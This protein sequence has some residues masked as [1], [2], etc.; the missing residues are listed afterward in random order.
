MSIA[1][2]VMD[3]ADLSDVQVAALMQAYDRD[4]SKPWE[5]DRNAAEACCDLGL[6][7]VRRLRDR[8]GLESIVYVLTLTGADLV[9]SCLHDDPP[10]LLPPAASSLA[11][12]YRPGAVSP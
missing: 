8:E 6:L 4:V 10:S 11:E 12:L 7:E 2:N 9:R 1:P 3:R 5:G